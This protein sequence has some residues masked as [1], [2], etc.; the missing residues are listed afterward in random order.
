MKTLKNLAPPLEL[1][2]KIPDGKFA[3]SVLVWWGV[4][5][6]DETM[7][8]VPRSELGT[9][10]HM[11]IAKGVRVLFPAPTLQEILDALWKFKPRV[12]RNKNLD[13]EVP[14]W[15]I[16]LNEDNFIGHCGFVQ[17]NPAD[18][19]LKLW[20]R[21]NKRNEANEANGTNKQKGE[22]NENGN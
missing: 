1:C 21:V 19:A 5:N 22:Q 17:D 4:K 12:W 18:A 15:G 7:E 2:K 20:L 13:P 11:F 10:C 3:D 6:H 9:T 8:V 14:A 16:A